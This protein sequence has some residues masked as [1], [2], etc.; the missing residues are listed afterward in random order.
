MPSWR[1]ASTRRGHLFR[2]CYLLQLLRWLSIALLHLKDSFSR[3]LFLYLFQLFFLA[4]LDAPFN[5]FIGD[6]YRLREPPPSVRDITSPTRLA[7]VVVRLLTTSKSRLALRADTPLRRWDNTTGPQR[8]RVAARKELDACVTWSP[9]PANSR[10]DSVRE[11]KQRNKLRR[12]RA[13]QP[14]WP[15]QILSWFICII[16][17]IPLMEYLRCCR[18]GS[19]LPVFSRSVFAWTID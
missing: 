18:P 16:H 6:D 7:V 13:P 14:P 12:N 9:W 19:V 1:C 3:L 11:L 5:W 8:L 10:M 17:T 4:T 2:R 15:C